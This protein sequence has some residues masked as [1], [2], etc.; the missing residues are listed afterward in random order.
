MGFEWVRMVLNGCVW[1]SDG[2]E[3]FGSCGL[4]TE[5]NR[6]NSRLTSEFNFSKNVK[7]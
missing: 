6:A 1:V 4:K 3:G 2:Y 5:I 7:F